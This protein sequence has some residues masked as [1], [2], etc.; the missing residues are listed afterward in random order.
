MA[1]ER[2]HRASKPPRED[3]PAGDEA[4]EIEAAGGMVM[5][6][7]EE[8]AKCDSMTRNAIDTGMVDFI[9]PVE[10]MGEQL[11]LDIQHPFLT[12]RQIPDLRMRRFT[13]ATRRLVPAF[14][15]ITDRPQTGTNAGKE[16][17]S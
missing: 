4:K 2:K 15:D 7:K 17:E 13:P 8:Q 11:A 3:H 6:Q 5:A 10:K 14:E 16:P 12:A 1:K 9:L